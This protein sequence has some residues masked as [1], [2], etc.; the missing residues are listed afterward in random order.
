MACLLLWAVT[1][2][3]HGRS[4]YGWCGTA[5]NKRYTLRRLF[6]GSVFEK[7]QSGDT[8]F[9]RFCLTHIPARLQCYRIALLGGLER[10]IPGTLCASLQILEMVHCIILRKYGEIW[11]IDKISSKKL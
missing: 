5:H 11:R 4:S 2:E 7:P 6:G 3:W 9:V 10:R 1:V 8:P